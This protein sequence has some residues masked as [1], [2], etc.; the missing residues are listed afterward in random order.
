[1]S[2]GGVSVGWLSRGVGPRRGLGAKNGACRRLR[3]LGCDEGQAVEARSALRKRGRG[4]RVGFV[5]RSQVTIDCQSGA[6]SQALRGMALSGVITGVAVD[7]CAR[8]WGWG[9]GWVGQ[10]WPLAGFRM[11]GAENLEE[12]IAATEERVHLTRARGGAKL[13]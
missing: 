9:G 4:W 10:E 7:W 8:V 12:D 1:V 11:G 5:G 13:R 2:R 6:R 3:C